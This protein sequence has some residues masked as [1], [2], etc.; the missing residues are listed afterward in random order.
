MTARPARAARTS[1]RWSGTCKRMPGC[2]PTLRARRR[3]RVRSVVALWAFHC[4]N[5][6]CVHQGVLAC[7]SPT[8][9]QGM[10]FLP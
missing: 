3:C 5:E 6:G 2:P 1:S 7:Y 4:A 9:L 10:R 8:L